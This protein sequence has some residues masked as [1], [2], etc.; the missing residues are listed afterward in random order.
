MESRKLVLMSLFAGR[1]GDTDTENKRVD[2]AG[3]GESGM[4]GESSIVIYILSCVK[5]IAGEKLFYNTGR[6][7]CSLTTWRDGLGAGEG[8]SRGRQ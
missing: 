3:E 6:A 5:Q 1:N 8:G 7:W 2:T 4:N